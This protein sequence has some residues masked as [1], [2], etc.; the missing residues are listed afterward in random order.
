M[1]IE[2]SKFLKPFI[3]QLGLYELVSLATLF[4]G[5]TLAVLLMLIKNEGQKG[6]LFLS[7]ALMVAIFKASGVAAF[8]LTALGPFIYFYV[9]RLT[10]PERQF[11][12]RDLLLFSPVLIAWWLP[13]WLVLV[14]VSGYLY[15]S[16]RLIHDFYSRL[17]P[18]LMDKPRFAFRRLEQALV[19]MWVLCIFAVLNDVFMFGVAFVLMGVA[20][21]LVL[22]LC[23]YQI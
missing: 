22:N 2:L 20:A 5:L 16:R 9:R 15:F 3:F 19:L 11:G 8:L 23:L 21:E 14:S 7:L 12:R 17:T 13:N 10:S 1:M 18:V 4:A 6:R